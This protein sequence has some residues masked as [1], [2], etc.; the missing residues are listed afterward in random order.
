MV[1]QPSPDSTP[2]PAVAEHPATPR[3]WT[4]T[5]AMWGLLAVL[6]TCAVV[7]VVGGYVVI[8]AAVGP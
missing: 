5:L 4:D 6:F 2:L 8:C 1:T 3:S 7:L